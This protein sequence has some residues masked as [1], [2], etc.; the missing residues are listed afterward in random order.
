MFRNETELQIN[1]NINIMRKQHVLN[2]T[3]YQSHVLMKKIIRFINRQLRMEVVNN[4][5]FQLEEWRVK[6]M[7]AATTKKLYV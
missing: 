2:V 3:T 1:I 7:S 4:K 6:R 5:N